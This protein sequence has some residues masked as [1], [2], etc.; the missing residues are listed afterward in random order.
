MPGVNER[1]TSIKINLHD[2][3]LSLLALHIFG[4]KKIRFIYLRS[5]AV[6]LNLALGSLYVQLIEINLFFILLMA[7]FYS[8]L[9]GQFSL[10][11]KDYNL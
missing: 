7:S 9:L 11:S 5:K 3:S 8:Y 6:Q 4:Q 2:F 1:V 10:L